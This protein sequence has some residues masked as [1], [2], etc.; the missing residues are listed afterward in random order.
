[1]SGYAAPASATIP[2]KG[3]SPGDYFHTGAGKRY[4]ERAKGEIIT[5]PLRGNISVL[6]GSGGNIV[7][8]SGPEGKFLVDAG[9]SPSKKKLQDALDRIS[10]SP[11]K[12]VVN[13]H[14][15]W[16]HTD[17]NAWM[18]AAGATIVA[19][20]HTFR[21]LT[22][23]THVDDWN[24][25]FDPVPAGARPTLLVDTEKSFDFDGTRIEVDHLGA[26]HTDGDLWASFVKHDVLP[27][28]VPFGTLGYP[29]M[30][31]KAAAISTTP[32]HGQTRPSIAPR[33][34]LLS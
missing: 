21:H 5:E 2:T 32:S 3:N 19:Q 7:V 9:I 15:H 13:T 25:T 6:R 20:Q 34:R 27:L 1:S 31:T 12:Y 30:D 24:W 33:T 26:G 4:L 17:G 28:G 18:H 11:L 10:R 29:F 8:L 14:W 23:T 16:D 22:E